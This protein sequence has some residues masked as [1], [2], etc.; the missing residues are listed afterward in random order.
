MFT[1]GTTAKIT[2]H[3]QNI[4]P[5]ELGLIERVLAVHLLAIVR[6]RLFTESIKGHTF[7]EPRRNNAIR[8]NIVAT[9]GDATTGNLLNLATHFATHLKDLGDL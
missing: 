6:K 5:L 1:G 4:C 2:V 9:E 3:H 7:E 8:I